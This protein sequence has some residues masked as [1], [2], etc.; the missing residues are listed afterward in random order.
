[1]YIYGDSAGSS[2]KNE[3]P[4]IEEVSRVQPVYG[5]EAGQASDDEGVAGVEADHAALL[6]RPGEVRARPPVTSLR[7]PDLSRGQSDASLVS[8][9]ENHHGGRAYVD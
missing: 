7:P 2:L 5:L 3:K 9:S 1:M 6:Q 4:D 8:A